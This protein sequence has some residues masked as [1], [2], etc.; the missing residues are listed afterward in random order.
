MAVA[1]TK[2]EFLKTLP[3]FNNLS[4][5]KL[6]SISL[7]FQ[8]ETINAGEIFIQ[9]GT[10]ASKVYLIKKG[11]VRV[12]KNFENGEEITFNVVGQGELIG[13]MSIIDGEPRS[14]SV[15]ALQET[16]ALTLNKESFIK[17]LKENPDLALSL[18][19]NM[20]QGIRM[21]DEHLEDMLIKNLYERTWKILNTLSG[22][23]PNQTV[24]LSHEEL[25]TIVGATRARVTE[26]LDQLQNEQKVKIS[27]RKIIVL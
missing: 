7:L 18:L 27:P 12:F 14:A 26:V 25:A 2:L 10:I 21:N 15:Q 9:E 17:I 22:Y 6:N 23:F 20:S 19:K 3:L 16:T 13:E 5:Q 4:S 1:D 11:S 24:T 8:E